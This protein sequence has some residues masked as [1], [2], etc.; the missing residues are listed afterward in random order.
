MNFKGL[1]GRA[2]ETKLDKNGRYARK[3]R[4]GK[5]VGNKA[6]AMLIG[7][8]DQKLRSRGMGGVVKVPT[9]VRASQ[10]NHV[11]GEYQ[12][13]P[14]SQRW[15]EMPDGRR[16]QRDLYS[17]FLLQHVNEA[18]DGFDVAALIRDYENFVTLHDRMIETLKTAPK[19]L[20]SMGIW[21][22]AS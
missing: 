6:P 17:A 21:R 11:T 4:F 19:T 20:T 2:K 15:N 7:I 10:F 1:Q 12:K 9:T 16:I 14:L 5:S 3:K 8:L 18:Q 13:K 22:T